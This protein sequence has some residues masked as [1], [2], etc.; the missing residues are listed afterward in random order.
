VRLRAGGGL[1][2]AGVRMVLSADTGCFLLA[3]GYGAV[4]RGLGA[5]RTCCL[6]AVCCPASVRGRSK[7]KLFLEGVGLAVRAGSSIVSSFESE[8]LPEQ[9]GS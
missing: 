9:R 3:E 1:Q 6:G 7:R 2:L 4:R 8:E 5:S